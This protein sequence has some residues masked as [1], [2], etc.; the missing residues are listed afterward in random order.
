MPTP[1]PWCVLD[2]AGDGAAPKSLP[3][4]QSTMVALLGMDQD[5]GAKRAC[6]LACLLA[7][8]ST[9]CPLISY[10]ML[11]F[12]HL[13]ALCRGPAHHVVCVAPRG[14]GVAHRAAA[15]L[16]GSGA[17][18][19]RRRAGMVYVLCN[20]LFCAGVAALLALQWRTVAGAPACKQVHDFNK[21]VMLRNQTNLHLHSECVQG[22]AGPTKVAGERTLARVLT[23]DKSLEPALAFVPTGGPLVRTMLQVRTV[24]PQLVL[25]SRRKYCIQF[26][27]GKCQC[28][29]CA[30]GAGGLPAPLIKAAGGGGGRRPALSSMHGGARCMQLARVE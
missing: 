24:A 1:T 5:S 17:V 8:L 19:V 26:P 23:L 4:L 21:G 6:L 20:T 9:A 7:R 22:S 29:T 2:D 15:T 10:A 14:G 27:D 13:F 25:R 18:G 11:S 28:C 30:R 3:A 16:E 12:L